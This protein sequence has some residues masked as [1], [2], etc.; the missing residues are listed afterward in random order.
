M[1]LGPVK[2]VPSKPNAPAALAAAAATTRRG[3]RPPRLLGG[4]SFEKR[5]PLGPPARAVR[6]FTLRMLYR[7]VPSKDGRY[8]TTART[9]LATS[10]ATRTFSLSDAGHRP[11]AAPLSAGKG[12][13][14]LSSLIEKSMENW[15]R[16]FQLRESAKLQQILAD[17]ATA[18]VSRASESGG[19]GKKW[20]TVVTNAGGVLRLREGARLAS[21]ELELLL[22]SILIDRLL[23][24]MEIYWTNLALINEDGVAAPG[25]KAFKMERPCAAESATPACGGLR[26]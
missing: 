1:P 4:A 9:A 5:K 3:G 11:L 7:H 22:A 10:L 12:S 8:N 13:L 25:G 17:E 15:A 19:E 26:R 23:S 18:A 6:S 20:I 24:E 21:F 14:A 2:I 16:D